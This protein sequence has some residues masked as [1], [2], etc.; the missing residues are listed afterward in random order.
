MESKFLTVWMGGYQYQRE[1]IYD[2]AC[3]T[4]FELGML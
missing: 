2:D 1:N 4:R 3:G